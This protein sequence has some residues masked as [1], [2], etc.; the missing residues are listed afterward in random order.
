M[1]GAQWSKE[2]FDFL[3]E[4]GEGALFNDALERE[5]MDDRD[6]A[7]LEQALIELRES[8]ARYALGGDAGAEAVG[9]IMSAAFLIGAF[10]TVTTSHRNLLVSKPAAKGGKTSRSPHREAIQKVLAKDSKTPALVI[11]KIIGATGN[12]AFINLVSRIKKS[13]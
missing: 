8:F 3:I 12:K 5:V 1:N 2:W 6:R 9:R 4:T 10:G 7:E 13:N 11:A